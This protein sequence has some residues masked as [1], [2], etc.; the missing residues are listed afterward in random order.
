VRALAPILLALAVP[1][2]AGCGGAK[3]GQAPALELTGRV[4]DAAGILDDAA[5]AKLTRQLATLQSEVGPQMVVVTTT[6]LKGREI[7]DYSLDL[8]NAWAV[9][10]KDRNDGVLLLIAPNERKVRIEIGLGLEKVLS[11]ELCASIIVNDI[12][13]DFKAGDFEHGIADGVARLDYELRA[14]LQKGAAA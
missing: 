9:G 1:A 4:V 13:P 5:E 7:A 3:A 2:L 6:D 10:D 8:A 11:D 12:V 14:K